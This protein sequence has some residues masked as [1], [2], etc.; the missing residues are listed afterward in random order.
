MVTAAFQR[1]RSKGNVAA[2][3]A[4]LPLEGQ[5]CRSARVYRGDDR[6]DLELN[7]ERFARLGICEYFI[8]DVKRQRLSGYRLPVPGTPYDPIIPQQGRWPSRVL[9]LELG[10]ESDRLR[11]Y[12][13]T[14]PLPELL[15]LAL[16]GEAL[17][18]QAL[19]RVFEAERRAEE[20]ARRAE[21]KLAAPRRKL[22]A[23]TQRSASFRHCARR[24]NACAAALSDPGRALQ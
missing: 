7:V 24:S 16:R 10:L 8:Y 1:C 6:K 22:A 5:S 21:R 23:R 18:E 20:E 19:G 9:G 4:T 12:A 15:E 11:L 17:L 13:G 14:A 3:R 2:R